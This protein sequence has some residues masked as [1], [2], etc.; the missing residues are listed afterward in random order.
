MG[1]FASNLRGFEQ[2]RDF[3]ASGTVTALI[4][5]P[6]ALLFVRYRLDLALAGAA[7]VVAAVLVLLMGWV[8][9]HRLRE[10][11]QTTWRAGAQR[12]ATLV[13]S[14]TGIETIKAQGAEG[15]M[16]ARWERANAFLAAT[17]VKMRGVSSTAMY[18]PATSRRRPQ[19][20]SSSAC[21]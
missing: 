10:L 19:A 7:V 12:N 8:L 1:S 20:S 14:L 17:G 15:V 18:S 9:Q 2:V 16:Q 4:D 5:L 21:T 3:I 13:E 11:S 6:F